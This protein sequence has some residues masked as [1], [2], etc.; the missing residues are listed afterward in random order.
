[1][2]TLDNADTK[3]DHIIGKQLHHLAGILPIMQWINIF[4]ID[5]QRQ[6]ESNINSIHYE[7]NHHHYNGISN[8]RDNVSNNSKSLQD[9]CNRI[10]H[11]NYIINIKCHNHILNIHFHMHRCLLKPYKHA[12]SPSINTHV[13]T[14]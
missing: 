12:M 2:K 1:M 9:L 10:T 7:H 4:R 11:Q 13:T 14:I 6:C 8:P 5:A 3:Y